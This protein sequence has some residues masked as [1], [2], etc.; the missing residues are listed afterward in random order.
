MENINSSLV[1]NS[2]GFHLLPIESSSNLMQRVN[3]TDSDN[4]TLEYFSVIPFN[5]LDNAETN[6]EL[7]P[8]EFKLEEDLNTNYHSSMRTLIEALTTWAPKNL[9][10]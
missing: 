8:N 3:A 6:F 7:P 10:T 2:S 4:I 5:T 1:F 9:A